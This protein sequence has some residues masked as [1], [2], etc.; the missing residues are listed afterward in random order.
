[1][2]GRRHRAAGIRARSNFL[3]RSQI[4][5][6]PLL[7]FFLGIVILIF[8]PLPQIGNVEIQGLKSISSN[9]PSLVSI[10]LP[11]WLK[12]GCPG[13]VS[14]S[15][16]R[17]PAWIPVWKI[18]NPKGTIDR[19]LPPVSQLDE[20]A[21]R[22]LPLLDKLKEHKFFRIFKVRWHDALLDVNSV[23]GILL[24]HRYQYSMTWR[25]IWSWIVSFLTLGRLG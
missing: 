10:G 12:I 4:I 21:H 25:I 15:N 3:E 23:D 17:V 9:L 1:M 16:Y 24:V 14:M 2:T 7:F 11:Q 20:D 5:W 8:N 19:R 22:L 18:R 13:L 6:I